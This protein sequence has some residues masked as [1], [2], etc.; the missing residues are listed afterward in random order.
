ML[1]AK[2]LVTREECS[3]T[4]RRQ[5][6]RMAVEVIVPR[7]RGLCSMSMFRLSSKV[8]KTTQAVSL[9]V[10]LGLSSYYFARSFDQGRRVTGELSRR[11]GCHVATDATETTGGMSGELH[12]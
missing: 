11:T 6:Q 9:C 8:K 5:Q 7:L 1:E 4:D 10:V 3:A 2:Y 12:H